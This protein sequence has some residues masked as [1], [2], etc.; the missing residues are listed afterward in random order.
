MRQEHV[1]D[2]LESWQ[3]A[4][5]FGAVLLGALAGSLIPRAEALE[6]AI[7]PALAL[8]LF[9]TFLQVPLR[10]LG[11]AL[12]DRRF[13]GALLGV[14]FVIVPLLVTGLIQF[15]PADPLVR[16]GILIVLLCPC[17]DYVVTFSHL[18]RAD[19]RLLLAST[20][21][22]L[23]VQML[24]LPFY[25]RVFLG[26]EAAHL[27]QAG[28]FLHAFL[29]L[30]AFPLLFAGACQLWARHS[31]SGER[32]TSALGLLPVPATALVL[33]IVIASVLPQLNAAIPAALRVLPIYVAFHVVIPI[34]A[35]PV[36][37]AVGLPPQAGRAIAFSAATRNSL[38]VLPL[39]LAVPGAIPLLPAVIVT[40]TLIELLASLI[41]IRVMPRLGHVP[42][43][44]A[45]QTLQ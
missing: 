9:V 24:M 6:A 32:L 43:N 37:K 29:W 12:R 21:A 45:G 36:S 40:Q 19:A 35:W 8:M 22:L 38:V 41:Y 14:N 13:L 2:L 17:I 5:Y 10:E 31:A 34:V 20:P 1:R 42:P 23:I 27:V 4:I 11:Q 28:P 39:A 16:F 18:G 3:I 26:S 25:L 30:I 44:Q 15:A 7:N 33:F